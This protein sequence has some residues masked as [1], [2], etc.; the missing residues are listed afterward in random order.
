MANIN[1]RRPLSNVVDDI[2]LKEII[3][4][5]GKMQIKLLTNFFRQN[6]NVQQV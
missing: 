2:L 6:N 1:I 3:E 4:N 5:K